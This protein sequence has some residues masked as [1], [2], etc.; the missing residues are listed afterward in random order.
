MAQIVYEQMARGKPQAAQPSPQGCNSS[1]DALQP[2]ANQ[3]PFPSLGVGQP[4]EPLLL[5]QPPPALEEGVPRA[6]LQQQREVAGQEVAHRH[7]FIC[8]CVKGWVVRE[9]GGTGS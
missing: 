4:R 5:L 7:L 8:E 6:Q 1:P 9:E 3:N 2:H